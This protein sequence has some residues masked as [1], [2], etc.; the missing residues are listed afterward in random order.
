MP[1]HDVPY[2]VVGAGPVGLTAARLLANDGR[3]CLIVDRRDGPRR[4]PAAHVV[5]ARTLEIF[6]Q[7]GF[8]MAAIAAIAKDP[9]DAGHVNWVSR[10]DGQLIGRLPF[11]RQGPDVLAVTPTPLRNISQHHLEPLLADEVAAMPAVDLRYRTEW[12]S[13]DQGADG[14]TSVVRRLDTGETEAIRSRYVL[15]AD[16]AGSRVRSSLGI[17]MIGPPRIE[18]FVMI[19]F[20]ADLRAVVMDRPGV[21]HFVMDPAVS[22][23]FVAHDIDREWVFMQSFDPDRESPE[24]FAADRCTAIVQAAIG[25]DDVDLEILGTGTWHMSA[26]VAAAMRDRRIFLIGDAAHRFP[27]TGGLGLNTG[28][29]DAHGL[30]WKLGAVDD[31][32]A[33]PSMLDSYEAERRPVAATNCEQSMA[34]AFEL[35]ALVQALGLVEDPST[36]GLHAALADPARRASIDAAVAR[37]TTHFDMIGLQ[38]GYRYTDGALVRVGAAPAPISNPRVFEP[39][40][41]VGCR[42]PHAWLEDGSSTLDLVSRSGITLLSFGAHDKWATAAASVEA[43]LHHIP[44]VDELRGDAIAFHAVIADGGALLVRPDQHIAW[45]ADSPTDVNDL[46]DALHTMLG[47]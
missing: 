20:R 22:G 30:V 5:N 43:P 47:R 36:D 24:H 10:L 34:N 29:A 31:G 39:F 41:D 12:V 9:A 11:E 17:E 38:L 46:V 26:Q 14:V 21:L 19:H 3:R 6:R 40:A 13:S 15:A 1:T 45:R 8:D 35:L 18:S 7:A 23:C 28:V 37:Q 2:L 44:I 4:Q 33:D 42:L 16:G 27:P 25:N 32:W